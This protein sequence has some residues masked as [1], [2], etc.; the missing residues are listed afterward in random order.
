MQAGWYADLG[1]GT[2][3]MQ[4][5]EGKPESSMWT[6]TKMPKDQTHDVVTYRCTRCGLLESY[7]HD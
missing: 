6:G 5:V 3:P 4:W 7:V 2:R 1:G